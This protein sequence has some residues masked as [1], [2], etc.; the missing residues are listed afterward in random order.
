MSGAVAGISE[1][2]DYETFMPVVKSATE[3]WED[4]FL[5]NVMTMPSEVAVLKPVLAKICDGILHILQNSQLR[6]FSSYEKWTVVRNSIS[7]NLRNAQEKVGSMQFGGPGVMK[8]ILGILK[9]TSKIVL[10][11]VLF[12]NTPV[13]GAIAPEAGPAH[14]YQ[15]LQPSCTCML[16]CYLLLCIHSFMISRTG[17]YRMICLIFAT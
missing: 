8:N 13:I 16:H 6:R 10:S 2:G 1:K 14:G 4:I 9:R 15:P 12:G 3:D 11:V 5:R 7:G 17:R